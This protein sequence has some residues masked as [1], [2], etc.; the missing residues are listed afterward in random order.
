MDNE[1][2]D[3]IKTIDNIDHV[4]TENNGDIDVNWFEEVDLTAV[5]IQN[6]FLCEDFSN[7][8]I[9]HEEDHYSKTDTV[10]AQYLQMILKQLDYE[11]PAP[12][13]I[14]IDNLPELQMINDNTSPTELARHIDICHFTLQDWKLYGSIITI[15][16][17]GV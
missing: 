11:Q 4:S 9:L 12:N 8:D 7:S 16:I 13:P 6:E 5:Q 14:Y 17:K 10:S 3:V 15:H 1:N 2:S